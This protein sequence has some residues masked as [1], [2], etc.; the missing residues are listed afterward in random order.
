MSALRVAYL[1]GRYP[2]MTHTFVLREVREL[3]RL[4]ADVQTFSVWR[5]QPEDLLSPVDREEFASTETLLP[6]RPLTYVRAHLAAAFRNPGAYARSLRRAWDLGASGWR[7]R[8]L[9]L[10]WF[11]EA[12]VMWDHCRRRGLNHIHVHL[13]GTAPAVANLTVAL[14][15]DL[16]AEPAWSY[17][18]TIHG[19]KEFYDVVREGLE[20]KAGGARFVVCISDYTRSQVMA[21]TDESTWQRQHVVRCGVDPAGYTVRDHGGSGGPMQVLT[22][23]RLDRMKGMPILLDAIADVVG[24][25]IPV[26]LK[27]VGD[28]PSRAILEAQAERLGIRD[29][30]TWVGA[31]G[32]D[33]MPA[34]Y[35]A[36]DVFCLPSFAEGIPIV[37]MEAM[38]T[39]LPVVATRITAIPELV[40]EEQ[41]GLLVRA[42]R[43]DQ[44]ADALARLAQD[45]ELR[46][47]MGRTARAKIE[48]EYD[49]HGS[50]RRLHALFSRHLGLDAGDAAPADHQLTSARG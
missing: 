5:S 15:N 24:R 13:N 16:G 31:V 26:E 33:K 3:R 23:G 39:G 25:G 6:P 20:A 30:V 36:A 9:S 18:M 17:S 10:T 11:A 42:G 41:S 21:F 2:Q 37:L 47:E 27:V 40:D 48:A 35:A 44:L 50:A 43:S 28:G 32:Q 38:A 34:Q 45:P 19:S 7:G 14:A 4:G 46:R 1:V 8:A 22:V 49:L 12:A 29:A